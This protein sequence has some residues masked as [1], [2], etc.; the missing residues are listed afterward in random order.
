MEDE[1]FSGQQQADPED[2]WMEKLQ[3]MLEAV[4]LGDM[5]PNLYHVLSTE[6]KFHNSL[7][8]NLLTDT[9]RFQCLDNTCEMRYSEVTKNFWWTSKLL[10]GGRFLR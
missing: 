10:F 1:Y 4:Q 8:M 7:A 2:H 3:S 5:L 6:N 9:L